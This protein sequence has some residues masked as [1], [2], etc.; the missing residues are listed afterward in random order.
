MNE[1]AKLNEITD[2]GFVYYTLGNHHEKV[3]IL[4]LIESDI[5]F[6]FDQEAINRICFIAGKFY[7]HPVS[8][9][10]LS[11]KYALIPVLSA[12]YAI[13]YFCST[14]IGS[15]V[16]DLGSIYAFRVVAPMAVLVYSFIFLI[17]SIVTEI[18]NIDV[19]RRMYMSSA[20][21][22]LFFL[23]FL[24]LVSCIPKEYFLYESQDYLKTLT[25]I[26]F[27]IIAA[28]IVSFI[29]SQTIN[30]YV[31]ASLK[32]KVYKQNRA[33]LN[34]FSSIYVSFVLA[35]LC[36]TFIDSILFCS[37]AFYS[38]FD[39]KIIINIIICQFIIKACIDGFFSIFSASL[40]IKIKNIYS[41]NDDV[42]KPTLKII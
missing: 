31:L 24:Y 19:T 8:R 15:S 1:K 20:V 14:I 28:S 32:Y 34:K 7:H 3:D 30:A 17:D 10:K 40:C 38:Q 26:A 11:R 22:T 21:V 4:I 9:K 18:Y 41:I 39:Y 6:C 37:I 42:K 5:L 16:I 29:M 35:G 33:G 13:I 12:I 25:S 36:A 23:S 27:H 2:D